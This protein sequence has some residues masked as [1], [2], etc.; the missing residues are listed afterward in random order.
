MHG[1]FKN[2]KNV[3]WLKRKVAMNMSP[4]IDISKVENKWTV[5]TNNKDTTFEEG[6]EF[7][8]EFFLNKLPLLCIG[9]CQKI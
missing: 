9:S 3:G 4:S 2:K 8:G 1:Y 5:K 7:K 6:V